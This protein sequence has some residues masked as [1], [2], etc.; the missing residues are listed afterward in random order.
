MKL[1]IVNAFSINMLNNK[2]CGL[3]FDKIEN[4]ADFLREHE[5]YNFIGHG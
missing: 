2:G 4:P 1:A 3:L 5:V